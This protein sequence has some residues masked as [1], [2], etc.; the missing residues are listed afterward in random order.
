MARP[1]RVRA[2]Q[3]GTVPTRKRCF[4]K[5]FSMPLRWLNNLVSRSLV[6]PR[7]EWRHYICR[8]GLARDPD[9]AVCLN[10]RGDAI[11]G[12]PAPMYGLAY[13]VYPLLNMVTRLHLCIRPIRGSVSLLANIGVSS[14]YADY[15][16][17]SWAGRSAGINP[18]RSYQ[19]SMFSSRGWSGS[20]P[21]WRNSVNQWLIPSPDD[22]S[23]VDGRSVHSVAVPR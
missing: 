22:R 15:I 3:A 9:A 4:W 2:A 6:C 21:R 11:A 19:G 12:K 18:R 23:I 16:Q 20:A 5:V 1:P 7:R 14:R 8:S 17:A 10:H 13:I